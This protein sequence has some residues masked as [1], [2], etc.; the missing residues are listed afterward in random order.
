MQFLYGRIVRVLVRDK[1]S[2]LDCAAIWIVAA[3]LEQLVVDFDVIVV[4]GVV[5]RD[6]YHLRHRVRLEAAWNLRAIRRT[7]TC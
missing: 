3:L 4:H 6:H 2:G 5:E 1:K 7:E